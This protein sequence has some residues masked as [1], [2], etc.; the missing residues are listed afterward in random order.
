MNLPRQGLLKISTHDHIPYLKPR[1]GHPI[2]FFLEPVVVVLN[3]LLAHENY[4]TVSMAGI[5]GGGWTTTLVAAA[6]TRIKKSFPVAGTYPIYLRSTDW[7]D[8]EQ[9]APEIYN[10]VNYLELYVLGS[11]G[12]GRKQLQ[13]LNQFDT[14]CF[15]GTKSETYHHIV[16][17]RVRDLGPGEFEVFL[18][19]SHKEHIISDDAMQQILSELKRD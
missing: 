4:S 8:Y 5:S 7:G 2:K 19:A 12:P 1:A 10:V 11:S 15:S 16:R 3:Y 18:D 9:S 6:D 17:D 13:I 14:C